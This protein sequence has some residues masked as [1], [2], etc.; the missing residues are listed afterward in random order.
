MSDLKR[1]AKKTMTSNTITAII[2]MAGCALLG[3]H[4]FDKKRI[5]AEWG[6]A[7]MR[8]LALV[9]IIMGAVEIAW[10]LSWFTLGDEANRRLDGWFSFSRGL[11]IGLLLA[12]SLS[13]QL[14]GIKK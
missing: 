12:L 11:L 9:A 1:S 8:I 4:S 6:K 13:R 2:I 10:D 5:F 7:C 14:I 3:Y